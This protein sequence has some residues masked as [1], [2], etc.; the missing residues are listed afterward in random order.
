MHE[1]FEQHLRQPMYL[2]HA[3]DFCAKYLRKVRFV[4]KLGD[5]FGPCVI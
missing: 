1:S 3:E 4:K 2:Q 5:V